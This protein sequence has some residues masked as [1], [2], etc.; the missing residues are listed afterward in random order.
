MVRPRDMLLGGVIAA[1][2]DLICQTLFEGRS[3]DAVDA[4]RTGEMGVVRA[5]CMA[6]FLTWYFP[7]LAR[8]IPGT[9]WP[10]VVARVCVDQ[11]I[12]APV[13][14]CGT[15]AA[16]SALRGRPGD[17]FARVEQQLI[18]TWRIGASFW[19]FVHLINFKFVPPHM[20]PLVAHVVS[21]P[22]NAVLSLRSNVSL[23][24]GEGISDGAGDG[25]RDSSPVLKAVR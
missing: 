10:R 13:T 19:P 12:G 8:T 2:G 9:T 18:P 24:S 16:T 11:A 3:I 22:W 15:F 6:P 25:K 1:T 23:T 14:I 21:V 17:T 4:R 20:Q 5:F 7:W